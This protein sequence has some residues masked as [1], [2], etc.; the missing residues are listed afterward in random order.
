MADSSLSLYP[1][2]KLSR[3]LELVEKLNLDYRFSKCGGLMALSYSCPS[4]AVVALLYRFRLAGPTSIKHR[5]SV[6][7]LLY[8][9]ASSSANYLQ[10]GSAQ[11]LGLSIINSRVV[12]RTTEMAQKMPGRSEFARVYPVLRRKLSCLGRRN[13]TL[14]S[15]IYDYPLVLLAE[16]NLKPGGESRSFGSAELY[17]RDPTR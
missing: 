10:S 2:P 15:Q 16:G 13:L 7:L 17:V 8:N 1:L 3:Y 12:G 5:K 9:A 4:D 11:S 14:Y 6:D